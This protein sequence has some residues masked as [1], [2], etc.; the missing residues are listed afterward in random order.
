M[1]QRFCHEIPKFISNGNCTSY[2]HLWI[3]KNLKSEEQ[4]STMW[5]ILIYIWVCQIF[6]FLTCNITEYKLLCW[7]VVCVATCPLLCVQ[8]VV[9]VYCVLWTSAVI[10]YGSQWDF[11]YL[12]KRMLFNYSLVRCEVSHGCR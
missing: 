12:V 10:I 3:L 7:I 2:N 1:P 5:W 11:T 6:M 9:W 4:K 8:H